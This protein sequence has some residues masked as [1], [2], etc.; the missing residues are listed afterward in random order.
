MEQREFQYYQF[1]WSRYFFPFSFDI[2]LWFKP[3]VG[4]SDII[5]LL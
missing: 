2:L 3:S 4:L 1:Y 5:D